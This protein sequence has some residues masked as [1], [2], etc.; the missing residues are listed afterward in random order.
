MRKID[1][2]LH[3]YYAYMQDMCRGEREDY[4]SGEYPTQAD[5]PCKKFDLVLER[6]SNHWSIFS[7]YNKEANVETRVT[8]TGIQR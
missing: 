7:C 4:E 3:S 6:E 1:K 5:N 2:I 8:G